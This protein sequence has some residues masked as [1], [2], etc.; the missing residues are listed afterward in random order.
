MSQSD[1]VVQQPNWNELENGFPTISVRDIE[2]Q[3]REDDLVVG[4]FGRG[5]YILDD[6]TLDSKGIT[7]PL[8]VGPD[9]SLCPVI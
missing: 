2:I 6:Y 4:T 5:I 8:D 1:L 9:L 7:E 3:R